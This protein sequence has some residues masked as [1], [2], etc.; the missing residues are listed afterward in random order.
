MAANSRLMGGGGGGG[1]HATPRAIIPRQF[2]IP[3]PIREI[4]ISTWTFELNNFHLSFP[5]S[6]GGR[7]SPGKSDLSVPATEII[8]AGYYCWS[9]RRWEFRPVIC[10]GSTFDF[11]KASL[12]QSAFTA[13]NGP[14]LY[15]ANLR[16]LPIVC[17]A[18][19]R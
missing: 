13:G 9:P 17:I 7:I 1:A 4:A 6:G 16:P 14:A 10:S 2:P 15:G 3:L 18:N 5:C 12:C 19:T 11:Q 8:P